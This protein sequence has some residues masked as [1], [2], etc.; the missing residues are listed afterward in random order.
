[1]KVLLAGGSGRVGTLVTP[2]LRERHDVRVLDIAPPKHEVEFVLET[3][4]PDGTIYRGKIDLLIENHG[5]LWIVD[6]KCSGNPMFGDR[7]RLQRARYGEADRWRGRLRRKWRDR[8]RWCSEHVDQW[9]QR[10]DQGR[11]HR[12]RLVVSSLISSTSKG[13][14]SGPA[15]SR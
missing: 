7:K 6:H 11:L 8:R 15:L 4:F 5:G 12:L 10:H 13:R 14:A 9:S 2:Y 1:M 3:E